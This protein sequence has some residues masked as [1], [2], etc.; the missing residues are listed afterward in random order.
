MF[1]DH[2]QNSFEP[3]TAQ[4]LILTIGY[5]AYHVYHHVPQTI[6]CIGNNL[7]N[8]CVYVYRQPHIILTAINFINNCAC[9]Y[10]QPHMVLTII[11]QQLRISPTTHGTDNHFINNCA[12]RQPHIVLTTTA[13]IA[14]HTWYR[15][16]LINNCAYRQ[17]HMVLTIIY[18]Q[19]RISPTTHGTDNHLSATAHI[20]NH[21]LY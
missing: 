12:Y 15:Q 7:I 8:N 19:L 14:N 13:H 21:T 16:S 20:A 9:T 6:H 17:P 11:Y 5:H 18:Q 4:F 1:S 10:C 3:N 2:S